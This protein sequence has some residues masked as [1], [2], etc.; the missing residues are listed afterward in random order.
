MGF[1]NW[2]INSLLLQRQG[3]LLLI[4]EKAFK[5]EEKQQGTA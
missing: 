3:K 4:L 2:K 5:H 1:S